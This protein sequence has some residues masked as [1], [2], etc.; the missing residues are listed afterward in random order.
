MLLLTSFVDAVKVFLVLHETFSP[1]SF[2][3]ATVAN[4]RVLP[5]MT[6]FVLFKIAGIRKRSLTKLAFEGFG[7][8]VNSL[9][10]FNSR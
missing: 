7:T 1:Y 2:V 10:T 4:V 3:V 6:S 5:G 9:V 8:G